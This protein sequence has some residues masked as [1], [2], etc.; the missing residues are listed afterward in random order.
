M[1]KDGNY[2][3]LL[4]EDKP[5]QLSITLEEESL[6]IWASNWTKPVKNILF[7]SGFGHEEF[8]VRL[9]HFYPEGYSFKTNYYKDIYEIE[10]R[11]FEIMP[12]VI[13]E[14]SMLVSH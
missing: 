2:A 3:L 5:A 13:Q 4:D 12:S 10:L 8:Q 11:I 7:S 14:K 6:R 9:A 1:S